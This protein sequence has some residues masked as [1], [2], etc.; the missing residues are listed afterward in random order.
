LITVQTAR[1][2]ERWWC[3]KETS[4]FEVA[5]M[6][7]GQDG[8]SWRRW[9][10]L[11]R[12]AEDLGFSGLYRSDHFTNTTGPYFDALELWASLT[13]LADNTSRIEFGPLVSPV[14]FRHLVVIA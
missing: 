14:S 9:R 3:G 13:W 10:R 8:I 12:A 11:A 1:Y 5:I 6:I 7:E 4:V 2:D